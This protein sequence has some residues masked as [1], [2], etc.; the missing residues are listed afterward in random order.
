MNTRD[1]DQIK[2]HSKPVATILRVSQAS[3]RASALPSKRKVSN[4]LFFLLQFRAHFTEVRLTALCFVS[5]QIG[6]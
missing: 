4:C 5:G 2:F 6:L 3:D 1:S